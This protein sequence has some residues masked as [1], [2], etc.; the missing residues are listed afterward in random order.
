M[1]VSTLTVSSLIPIAITIKFLIATLATVAI[2]LCFR[3]Y[4][5]EIVSLIGVGFA[6]KL[7][8]VFQYLSNL[9]FV[10]IFLWYLMLFVLYIF[11][12]C[13]D[14]NYL[15]FKYRKFI[16]WWWVRLGWIDQHRFDKFAKGCYDV[17]M[18]YAKNAINKFNKAKDYADKAVDYDNKLR[19]QKQNKRNYEDILRQ[20]LNVIKKK[21]KQLDELNKDKDYLS[22]MYKLESERILK[23]KSEKK[24]KDAQIVYFKDKE[25]N[26]DDGS[27]L[28]ELEKY[29]ELYDN[30]EI[31]IEDMKID[32]QRLKEDEPQYDMIG[33]EIEINKMK[34][35]VDV[36]YNQCIHTYYR[37]IDES[38]KLIAV[39]WFLKMDKTYQALLE[40]GSLYP[41]HKNK[42]FKVWF[43]AYKK[44]SMRS[45]KRYDNRK[46]IH[47]HGAL[48]H[49][50]ALLWKYKI[51]E[52]NYKGEVKERKLIVS[53][54]LVMNFGSTRINSRF[55]DSDQ[56]MTLASTAVGI[57][58]TINVPKDLIIKGQCVYDNSIEILKHIHHTNVWVNRS[59]NPTD[60]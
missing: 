36:Q 51:V 9:A 44:I 49:N 7:E 57:N 21:Q 26:I 47:S 34:F 2:N 50:D 18:K 1:R 11:I 39:D 53:M 23:E 43:W 28:Q 33:K 10:L 48:L 25:L 15:K 29:E 24:I 42:V 17:N 35:E 46:D 4:K 38:K 27:L 22:E 6:S 31:D 37:Y 8:N 45:L 52:I 5:T 3:Y 12:N 40:Y 41:S 30:L 58:S 59:L 19:L 14:K 54:S 55:H 56:V 13:C 20:K 60:F 32:I 16:K